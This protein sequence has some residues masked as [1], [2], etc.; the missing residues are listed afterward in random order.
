MDCINPDIVDRSV[1][2]F[3]AHCDAGPG[4]WHTHRRAQ[5]I[6]ASEGVL[7]VHTERGT[8]VVP[9][10]RGVWVLPKVAHKIAASKRFLLRTLYMEPEIMEL[11]P[12]C[13][14]VAV[15]RLVEEL[16]VAASVFGPD[17]GVEGPEARLIRVI[18]DR[19]PSLQVTPLHLP[20]PS[21][22]RILRIT[23]ML[24]ANPSDERN[25]EELANAAGITGR[26]AARLFTK[27]TCLS[28][29]QWRRQLRLLRALELLG[30]GAS[31][32][33]TAVEVGYQDVSSFIGVFTDAFGTTPAR[34]FK[35]HG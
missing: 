8:W 28:F 35:H 20:Q 29:G 34:Y 6:H 32:T 18:L 17:Y 9:P 11:P 25:I 24:E 13:C 26:T 15:D 16:L 22:P 23:H 7:T 27:E 10:Q 3:A 21:D 5:L 2:V 1:F 14:V 12:E 31:V 30:Q 4:I 33:R 19:L